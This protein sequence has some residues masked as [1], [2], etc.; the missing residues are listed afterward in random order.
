MHG[1]HRSA[2]REVVVALALTLAVST[3]V[4]SR[5]CEAAQGDRAKIQSVEV[6]LRAVKKQLQLADS[7][8][9]AR[10]SP[11]E[12]EKLE[13]DLRVIAR[14]VDREVRE[15]RK[16][17]AGFRI[18]P[19]S[20]DPLPP[21]A[22]MDRLLS[23]LEGAVDYC[24]MLA[25]KM[26][27]E[28]MTKDADAAGHIALEL[29]SVE[30]NLRSAADLRSRAIRRSATGIEKKEMEPPR[31]A[32]GPVPPRPPTMKT[33][34]PAVALTL[35]QKKQARKIAEMVVRLEP[36]QAIRR[37]TS[38]Y[39][40]MLSRTEGAGHRADADALS[41]MEDEVRKEIWESQQ[42]KDEQ[43]TEAQREHIQKLMEMIAEMMKLEASQLD[44]R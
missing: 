14:T 20:W 4:G 43:L 13:A 26:Q 27:Q 1:N 21:D 7:R 44:D 17:A 12:R 38:A 29:E 16:L 8:K 28:G 2:R 3:A 35:E 23:L 37:E 39:A 9:D 42:Q 33:K 25:L 31:R 5:P 18:A 36:E 41:A 19:G 11:A 24:I 34:R 30:Q 40:E 6:R 22:K 10:L 32:T 15:L